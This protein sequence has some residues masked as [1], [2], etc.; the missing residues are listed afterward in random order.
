MKMT[1]F[2]KDET[3]F[4][5]LVAES[6]ILV[7]DCTAT[8][9]GPCRMV[10]PLIDRLAAEYIDRVQVFKLDVDENKSIAQRFQLKSIPA[11]IFF[12]SGEQVEIVVGLKPYEEFAATVEKLLVAA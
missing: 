4:D 2:I 1:K 9:C 12:K 8:W 5:A 10:A 3:E 6:S 11:V 7:I